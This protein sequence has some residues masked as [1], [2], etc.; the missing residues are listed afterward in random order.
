MLS[1]VV[2]VLPI[3]G[4]PTATSELIHSETAESTKIQHKNKIELPPSPPGTV[5]C[6][7][8]EPQSPRDV[9]S[10]YF[11]QLKPRSDALEFEDVKRLVQVNTHFHGPAEHRSEGEYDGRRHDEEGFHC[12]KLEA[13]LSPM[14][15]RPFEFRHCKDVKVGSTYELHWVYSS[16]GV[17]IGE[18]LGGAFDRQANPNIIVQSQVYVVVNDHRYNAHDLVH[19]WNETLATNKV[20]YLGSTTGPSFNNV[21]CSPNEVTWH[22]DQKCQLI[23]AYSLDQLCKELAEEYGA[24]EDTRAEE[25]RKL[26]TPQLA[27]S[28]ASAI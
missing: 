15:R 10:D 20:R 1:I 9:S 19:G 16:G 22:V 27:S 24:E 12:D 5:S 18:G 23:S 25:P 14:Q 11:G 7:V 2:S 28:T 8:A 26:V 21:N 17:T 4:A 6:L 13:S 3:L